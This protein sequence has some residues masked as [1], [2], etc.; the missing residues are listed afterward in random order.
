M[1]HYTIEVSSA[2]ARALKKLP[3]D[4]GRPIRAA[5]DALADDPRPPGVKKLRD[6][7]GLYRI[8][9]GTHR[10]IYAVE[11]RALRVL[12]VDLGDRRDVYR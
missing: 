4:A 12:V 3:A 5:I 2:A 1:P 10:V 8:R 11:D 9:V 7:G 6:A